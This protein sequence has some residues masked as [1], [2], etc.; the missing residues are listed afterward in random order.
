ML[1]TVC[2]APYHLQSAHTHTHT[3]AHKHTH[4]HYMQ[5]Y[6]CLTV[7]D[8]FNFI[9]KFKH[10]PLDSVI[11]TSN[12]FFKWYINTHIYISVWVAC[13]WIFI[14]CI[15]S[16]FWYI[17]VYMYIVLCI[18]THYV[19][20]LYKYIHICIYMCTHILY[21]YIPLDDIIWMSKIFFF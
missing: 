10:I 3:H 11:W 5:S 7:S 4:T 8:F 16:S 1:T 15:Y 14:H 2:T 20:S 12:I 19:Y 13:M 21:L 9:S 17:Y 6:I 18:Y